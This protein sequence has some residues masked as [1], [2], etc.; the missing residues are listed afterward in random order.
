VTGRL[1]QADSYATEFEA[2]VTGIRKFEEGYGVI[3][4]ETLFYPETGGQPCDTGTIEALKIDRALEEGE[5][6][7]E[8][9]HVAS[10]LPAFA[11]GE[12]TK[13]RIDW[14][15]R[16]ANMQQ[17]TGQHILSQA[18]LR[19]LGAETVSSRLGTDHSTIDVSTLELTWENVGRVEVLANAVVFENRPVAIRETAPGEAS[20]VRVK[21]PLG[22]RDIR[23]VEVDDFDT[24]PCGG[25]HCRHTGEVGLI[26]ILGWE[27]VRETARVEFVCGGPALADYALKN[28]LL[29][30]LARD[31]TTKYTEVPGLVRGMAQAGRDL[32]HELDAARARLAARELGELE[33][34]AQAMG[35][36]KVIA[37][38]FEDKS[39]AELREFAARLTRETGTVALLASK[40]ERVHLVFSRS[41]DVAADMRKLLT[42]AAGLV[43]G[44]GGGRPEVAEGGGKDV[45][46][47]EA[48]LDEAG[49]ALAAMLAAGA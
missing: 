21:K 37:R 48:A 11:V 15:R 45:G 24:V 31:L 36:V 49:R 35:G 22:G 14:P 44:K 38:V 40:G 47:A 23:L 20:G 18:M 9:V 29:L 34:A 8:I 12:R 10:G 25:T 4:D 27:K 33:A 42:L 32:H 7:E 17:H 5:E 28:R 39:P 30:D 26:K 3:L 43:G 1:Y 19:V 16:F 46:R 13:G 41:R 6:G 2:T